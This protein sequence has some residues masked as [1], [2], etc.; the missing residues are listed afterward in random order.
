MI[1]A[2]CGKEFNGGHAKHKK[3][4]DRKKQSVMFCSADCKK[5]YV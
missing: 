2:K 4:D 1:C 3:V 5:M